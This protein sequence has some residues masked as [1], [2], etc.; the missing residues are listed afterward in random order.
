[1]HAPTTHAKYKQYRTTINILV[2]KSKRNHFKQYF[3]NHYN[4]YD[5]KKYGKALINYYKKIS[6]NTP[7]RQ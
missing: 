1:M 4:K 6:T 5:C 7:T 3:T 2:R